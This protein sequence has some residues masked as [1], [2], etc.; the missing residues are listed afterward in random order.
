LHS[1]H[2]HKGGVHEILLK[3]QFG[4]LNNSSFGKR[5]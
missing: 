5:E 3:T 1:Y 4:F 2:E